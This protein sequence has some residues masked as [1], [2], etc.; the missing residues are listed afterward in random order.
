MPTRRAFLLGGAATAGVVVAAGVGVEQGVLPGRP[1]VQAR[2]GLNGADGV[3]PRD[4]EPVPMVTDSFA[5]A[6]REQD[7]AWALWQPAGTPAELPVVIALHGLGQDLD[8]LDQTLGL[9]AYLAQAIDDGAPPF[10]IAAPEGG[11]S[12]W[13]PHDGDDAGAMVTDEL[14]PILDDRGFDIGRIGLLGWSMGGYGAL[15]LG[16]VLGSEQVSALVAS[17]PAI[18]TD[19]DD[20]SSSGF[21][22]AAEYEEYTV[23]GHQ[24]DLAGIPVRID[25]GT[26]DPFYRAVQDYVQAFPREAD[27]TSTFEPGAHNAGYWRRMLPA[28][29]AFLGGRVPSTT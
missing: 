22:D 29:L 25:V 11:T 20:A 19:A 28:Q 27:V 7:V 24:A 5:S 14:L 15:R 9:G 13:H 12:Y 26:G 10:A 8:Y 21:D 16:G 18:W 4:V 2:L 23:V 1:F 17:S 6:A 3:I